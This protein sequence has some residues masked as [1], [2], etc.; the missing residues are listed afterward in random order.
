MMQGNSQTFK[1]SNYQTLKLSKLE[2]LNVWTTHDALLIHGPTLGDHLALWCYTGQH[3]V[4]TWCSG[5]TL[6]KTW[7]PRNVLC[8]Y[9][10][11]H[12]VNTWCSG[13]TLATIWWHI[14]FNISTFKLYNFQTFKLSHFQT[15]KLW[16]GA[17]KSVPGK[18]TNLEN[19]KV[20]EI[21][22]LKIE[23]WKLCVA[24]W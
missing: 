3:L 21:A 7:W 12:F 19:L 11:Q 18:K 13:V 6:A 23:F 15:F 8:W 16:T 14:I 10:G 5:V 1:L 22:S 2:S 4:A 24:K 9:C 20:W 17:Q